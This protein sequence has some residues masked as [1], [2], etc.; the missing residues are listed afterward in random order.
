MKSDYGCHNKLYR[1]PNKGMISGVCA[2]IADYYSWD[3]G[4]V[5]IITVILGISFSPLIVSLYVVGAVFLKSKPRDLYD[6][7]E[8]ENYWQQYRKS[9]RDTM[10]ATQYKFRKLEKKLRKM[11]AYMTSSKYNLD[12]EFNKMGDK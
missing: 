12:R 4:L 11:E 2:G 10:S 1:L 9:P 6:D 8:E 5:R 7:Q 3:V